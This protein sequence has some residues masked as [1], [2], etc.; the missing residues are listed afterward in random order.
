VRQKNNSEF[1][2][3]K[4]RRFVQQCKAGG[5]FSKEFCGNAKSGSS[6]TLLTE[7]MRVHHLEGNIANLAKKELLGVLRD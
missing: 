5:V 3:Q 7:Q 6:D 2:P 4:Y 1:S